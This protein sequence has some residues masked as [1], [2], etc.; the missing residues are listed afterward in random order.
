MLAGGLAGSALLAPASAFAG[1]MQVA[2]TTSITGTQQA[3]VSGSTALV[4]KVSVASPSGAP[5]APSGSVKISVAGSSASC[6]TALTVP[7]SASDLTST[8]SCDITSLAGGQYK[9]SAAYTPSSMQFGSSNAS[10]YW[11]TVSGR[12]HTSLSTKLNCPQ[13][14]TTGHQGTCTLSVTD[15]GWNST[16]GVKAEIWLPSALSAR[17][18]ST[19]TSSNGSGHPWGWQPC[20]ISGNTVSASLGTISPGQTKKLSVTF[21]GHLTNWQK[22][23]G[24]MSR[25]WVHGSAWG[26]NR[27][28]SSNAAVTVMPR[29]YW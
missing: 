23:H 8:G 6:T 29:L 13:Q 10:S 1:V 15:N 7:S 24:R 22:S 12:H 18:C 3:D 4:V 27:S 20:S 28:A 9:L 17:S 2:T 19:N 25:V 14:V 21:T 26:S 5:L 11:V 16:G